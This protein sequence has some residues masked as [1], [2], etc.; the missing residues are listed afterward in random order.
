MVEGVT[1]FLLSAKL[2]YDMDATINFR[3]GIA[4]FR[5][6]SDQQFL[7]ERSSSNHLLLPR[8]PLLAEQMFL[9]DWA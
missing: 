5:K 3:K 6:L 1:P 7:L 9:R 2:L 8:R 4:V